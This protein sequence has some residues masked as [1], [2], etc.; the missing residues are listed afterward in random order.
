MTQ[1]SR[2]VT[3]RKVFPFSAI[4]LCALVPVSQVNSGM[5][6]QWPGSMRN[7]NVLF[8]LD[9][10]VNWGKNPLKYGL[11]QEVCFGLGYVLC[12]RITPLLPKSHVLRDE[13]GG[14][15]AQGAVCREGSPLTTQQPAGLCL[16]N[17]TH[18]VVVGAQQT[19]FQSLQLHGA[20]GF[21]SP[22]LP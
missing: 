12:R 18:G 2:P 9:P 3:I 16:P 17:G 22:N 1:W 8:F 14:L 11:V 13:N 5:K 19:S 6:S 10:A 15:G 21:S 20:G 7:E 4:S